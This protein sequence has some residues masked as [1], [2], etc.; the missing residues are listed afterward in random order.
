MVLAL[1]RPHLFNPYFTLQASAHY[2]EQHQHWPKQY[3]SG[4]AQAYRLAEKDRA[5]WLENRRARPQG[6][7]VSA[8]SGAG[9]T[10]AS[11]TM[12]WTGLAIFVFLIVHLWMFKFS[13]FES[14]PFGLYQ[15]VMEELA[16]PLLS[17]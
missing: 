3:L 1:A 11:R 14:M 4:K 5:T 9:A 2:D 15:V 6:Y 8:C 7:A 17:L 12:I 16:K 10:T 13:G